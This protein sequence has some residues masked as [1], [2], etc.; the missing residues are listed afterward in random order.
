MPRNPAAAGD[1]GVR[2]LQRHI[3]R[4]TKDGWLESPHLKALLEGG[5]NPKRIRVAGCGAN[6]TSVVAN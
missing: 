2:E 1:M 3:V 6:D 4:K 5:S